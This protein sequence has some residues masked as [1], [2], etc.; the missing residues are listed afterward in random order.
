MASSRTSISNNKGSGLRIPKLLTLLGNAFVR[1]H[2]QYIL[3]AV[4]Y[5]SEMCGQANKQVVGDVSRRM[6]KYSAAI[7]TANYAGQDAAS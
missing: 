3:Q 1:R 6:S 4:N 2:T 7:C 5:N